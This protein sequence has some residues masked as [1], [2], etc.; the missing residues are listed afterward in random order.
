MSDSS[1][2]ASECTDSAKDKAQLRRDKNRE[3]AR[4]YRARRKNYARDL[5]G[6]MK[7][8]KEERET[9]ERSIRHLWEKAWILLQVGE[10]CG[11]SPSSLPQTPTNPRLKKFLKDET[12]NKLK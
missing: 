4:K 1:K 11:I 2:V 6:K 12:R 5:S 7:S 10:T 8:L 3:S 9:I